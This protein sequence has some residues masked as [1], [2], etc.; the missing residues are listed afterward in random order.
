M[1][2]AKFENALKIGETAAIEFKRAGGTIEMDTFETV[3]SFSN[4]F[5]GDIYLGVLD[6]GTVVGV[7][8]NAAQPMV[9]NFISAIGNPEDVKVTA[10]AKIAQM[11]IRKQEIYTERRVYPYVKLKDLRLDLLPMIRILAKNNAGGSHL[12]EKL[13]NRDLLKSAGLYAEDHVTGKN[14]FNLA[15]VMLL[16]RDEVIRDI[17]PAYQTD[18]LVRKVNVDRYDDRLTVVTNLVESFEQLFK[19]AALHLPDKFYVEGAERKSLRNIVAREMLVNTLMH[20]EYSSSYQ[21]KFVIEQ[22]RMYVE[23]AN[24]ARFNGPITLSNLEPFPKNPLIASFFRNIGYSEKLGSLYSGVEPEFFEDDVFRIIQPLNENYS[25]DAENEAGGQKGGQNEDS[26]TTQKT[27]QKTAQKT[28]QKILDAISNN[29]NVTRLEL[30]EICVDAI[31]NNPNVTRLELS[32]I[33]GITADGV[34]WQLKNLA[35]S[36]RI[37]RIGGDRGGHWEVHDVEHPKT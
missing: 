21:A 33:C 29:P 34:K 4:R 10:T 16:G 6:N 30:S 9:K 7:P 8:E 23:N 3:C 14:G 35:K 32:E 37:A 27:T 18:A 2:L 13:S 28:T 20:R 31:S 36:G 1:N 17:C 12:W 11:Y 5:G 19:F 25:F 15:A 26:K 22:D 24:R